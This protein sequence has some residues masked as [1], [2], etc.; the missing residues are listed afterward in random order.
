[1]KNKKLLVL[2]EIS[3]FTNK[4]EINSCQES[5]MIR[6]AAEADLRTTSYIVLRLSRIVT[7]NENYR[8]IHGIYSFAVP[9]MD[10]LANE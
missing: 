10:H 9:Q 7:K 1:M 4:I 5:D 2:P 3:C 6:P 8:S